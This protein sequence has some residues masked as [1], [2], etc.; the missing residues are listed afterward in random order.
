MSKVAFDS[1]A[2]AAYMSAPVKLVVIMGSPTVF[3]PVLAGSASLPLVPVPQAQIPKILQ[4]KD[5]KMF[6]DVAGVLVTGPTNLRTPNTKQGPRKAAD[7]QLVQKPK[8]PGDVV[9]ALDF[10]AW[11]RVIP[12]LQPL[13][14]QYVALFK[15]DVALIE[16]GKVSIET[17]RGASVARLEADEAMAAFMNEY[18][19]G[20]TGGPAVVTSRWTH[21]EPAFNVQH[22]GHGAALLL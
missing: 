18:A 13:A 19:S 2:K 1:K 14:G 12:Q 9:Q 21:S 10:T 16:P 20:A 4:L 5:P 7:F 22:E 3:E 6:Y 11:E 8:K 17:S 15:L